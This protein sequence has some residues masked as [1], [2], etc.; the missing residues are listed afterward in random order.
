MCVVGIVLEH[1]EGDGAV[2]ED[3]LA[4]GRVHPRGVGHETGDVEES[5]GHAHR[6]EGRDVALAACGYAFGVEHGQGEA[7]GIADGR[8]EVE[9]TDGYGGK[10]I[11]L[12]QALQGAVDVERTVHDLLGHLRID[13]VLDTLEREA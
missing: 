9:T 11:A 3:H 5:V 2:C 4:D 12:Y 6:E 8:E 7:T 10:T 1:I 13:G